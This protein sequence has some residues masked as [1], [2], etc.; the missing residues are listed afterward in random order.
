MAKQNRS[1]DLIVLDPPRAGLGR[2]ALQHLVRL[3]APQL[4]YVSCDAATFAR[5][6]RALV[7]SR[8]AVAELH[9]LDLFPQ[10]IHTETI[11]VFR[12]R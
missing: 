8:Y 12:Q 10:T 5:D 1:P 2:D 4:V 7:D 6:A 11:A 3:R 9:L